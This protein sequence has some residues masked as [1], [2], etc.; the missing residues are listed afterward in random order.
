MTVYFDLET[1]GLEPHHPI[2]EAAFI[3]VDRDWREQAELHL[4]LQFDEAACDPEALAMNHYSRELWAM[5]AVDPAVGIKQ[6][7]K[8][9]NKFRS[10]RMTSYR[11]GQ[12]YLVARLAGYN[13]PHFD[14]QFLR[15]W[16]DQHDQFLGADPRVLCVMQRA[17]WYFLEHGIEVTQSNLKLAEVCRHFGIEIPQA[18]TALDDC[19]AAIALA[20]SL[21]QP[22]S[23]AA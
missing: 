1:G 5:T 21:C 12:E 17:L 9:L 16:A 22:S 23:V 11:T 13:G 19:R 8:F 14:R 18:H 7:A 20:K 15:R 10:I 6:V 4:R 3:A 2:I